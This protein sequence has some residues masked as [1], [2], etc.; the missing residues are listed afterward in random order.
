MIE[1]RRSVERGQADRG[2][3]R[4]RHSF[5]FADYHDPNHISFGPLRVINE[6]WIAPGQ[7]FGMHSHRD[8]EIITYVLSG[9]ITHRDSMGNQ[10]EIRPGNV[11]RMSAGT[12]VMHSEHNLS[13]ETT[14]MLQI[15]I[16]PDQAGISPGYE[17]RVFDDSSKRG[18][19]ALIA[20]P[21]PVGDAVKIHQD[22][23]V[24]AGLFTG[25][26]NARLTIAPGRRIYAHLARGKISVNGMLLGAG[27]AAK[28][29]A[30]T[31]LELSNGESAEVLVF[32]LP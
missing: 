16:H 32:D 21:Q 22:A 1:L 2:W 24:Y 10:S 6:D 18:R 17:E 5:S 26:E 19:L 7:G 25:T 8:M 29:S 3:L 4:S 31:S 14:H 30:E 15:W 13:Q 23:Q 12:G 20:S 27:D 9:A 11:Q 28:L